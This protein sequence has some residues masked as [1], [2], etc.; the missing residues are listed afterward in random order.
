MV[1][2]MDTCQVT[3]RDTDPATAPGFS[4]REVLG[5]SVCVCDGAAA[6]DM[7]EGMLQANEH[8]KFAF[9]N[10]NGAN[11]AFNDSNYR[12]CLDEFTVL[13]D[14]VGVDLASRILYGSPFP[15]NLN[16]TDF[17]PYLFASLPKKLK[18][19]LLGGMEGVADEAAASWSRRF[20]QHEFDVI[21]HGYFDGEKESQI[22]ARLVD[23]PVDILLVAFGNPKQEYW[24]AEHIGPSHGKVVFGVGALFDFA[25]N[26]VSRAPQQ[27][28]SLRLEWVYRLWLEPKRMWRRYVLGNPTF[29][30]RVIRQKLFGSRR[31]N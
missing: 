21:S 23:D 1:A 8:R 25:A 10:A 3:H 12:K 17:I 4:T 14:G 5:V 16:G 26:R 30:Q 29:V 15:E 18:V 7:I 27:L 9:L 13:P 31:S 11:I 2:D 22:L 6:V 19:G 20:P 28:I 24:I